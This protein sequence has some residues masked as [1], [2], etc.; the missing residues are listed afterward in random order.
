MKLL[1]EEYMTCPIFHQIVFPRDGSAKPI[2]I[3]LSWGF[4]WDHHHCRELM[5]NRNKCLSMSISSEKG[6]SIPFWSLQSTGPEDNKRRW[7]PS[8]LSKSKYV[9][10]TKQICISSK[11]EYLFPSNVNTYFQTLLSLRNIP[12]PCCSTCYVWKKSTILEKHC[13]IQLIQ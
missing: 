6:S 5:W 11:S 12:K 10:P 2:K 9:F 4:A 7:R 1:L 13:G 3:D 8:R